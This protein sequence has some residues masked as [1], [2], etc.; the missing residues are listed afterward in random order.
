MD[1]SGVASPTGNE[2][3]SFVV[4]PPEDFDGQP[5]DP[6]DIPPPPS[7][8]HHQGVSSALGHNPGGN[9]GHNP[10]RHGYEYN[11]TRSGPAERERE[12]HRHGMMR[13]GELRSV[14]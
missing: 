4:Q 6:Y 14:S 8:L 10:D 5:V 13:H 2:P 1:M 9:P 7:R 3:E 12:Q 11:R